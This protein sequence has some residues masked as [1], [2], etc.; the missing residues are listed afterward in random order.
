[1][2]RVNKASSAR[3]C[4]DAD[5]QCP[6]RTPHMPHGAFEGRGTATVH[7]AAWDPTSANRP[8]TSDVLMI[9]ERSS[10]VR[11]STQR[12]RDGKFQSPRAE[13]AL[14]VEPNMKRFQQWIHNKDVLQNHPMLMR[15]GSPRTHVEPPVFCFKDKH[16]SEW[17]TTNQNFYARPHTTPAG[18]SRGIGRHERAIPKRVSPRIYNTVFNRDPH[19]PDDHA[20][21]MPQAA[22]VA[23]RGGATVPTVGDWMEPDSKLPPTRSPRL[24]HVDADLR[25]QLL[26]VKVRS[27]LRRT[28]AAL[29]LA[30]DRQMQPYTTNRTPLPS[31]RCQ[32]P[33][34]R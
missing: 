21:A 32:P 8:W 15:D 20:K 29:A 5:R 14:S 30:A 24:Q 18:S 12:T 13:K 4:T 9:N 10:R 25:Q 27:E 11:P 33:V 19:L 6:T 34:R 1:M 7:A 31:P 22:R 16:V 2:F 3:R 28:A 23:T 26:E 17:I